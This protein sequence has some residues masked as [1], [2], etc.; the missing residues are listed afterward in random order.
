MWMWYFMPP[1]GLPL[2]L[3]MMTLAMSSSLSDG[4]FE[5]AFAE[6]RAAS[7]VVV[8]LPQAEGGVVAAK[9]VGAVAAGAAR[10]VAV[11][12]PYWGAVRRDVAG[13]DALRG[14]HQRIEQGV[15]E[16]STRH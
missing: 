4:S 7:P 13:G 10:V 1:L 14:T 6:R 2:F 9:G 3:M 12:A 11:H 16:A 5:T 8:L 15:E